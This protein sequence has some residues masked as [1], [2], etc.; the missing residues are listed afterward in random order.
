MEVF[1][2]SCVEYASSSPNAIVSVAQ[3]YDLAKKCAIDDMKRIINKYDIAK[4]PDVYKID[5]DKLCIWRIN[6][7]KIILQWYIT[8]KIVVV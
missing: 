3:N 4:R 2:V 8:E 7:S 1:V 6:T 5:Y